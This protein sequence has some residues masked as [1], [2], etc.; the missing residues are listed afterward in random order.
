MYRMER[1]WGRQR[2]VEGLAI[3]WKNLLNN[4]T[5]EGLGLDLE[6][7]YP[8]VAALLHSFKQKVE[9]APTFGDPPMI[10]KYA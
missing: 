6:F 2:M 10:F 4:R 3:R 5:P 7:S 1:G 9:H 8:A